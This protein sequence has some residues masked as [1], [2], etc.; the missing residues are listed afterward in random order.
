MDIK[1]E[2]FTTK[3]NGPIEKNIIVFKL[4]DNHKA[5]LNETRL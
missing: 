3:E 1:K 2:F 4:M 5:H